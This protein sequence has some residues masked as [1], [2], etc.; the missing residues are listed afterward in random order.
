MNLFSALQASTTLTTPVTPQ[1]SFSSALLSQFELVSFA[2]S[3]LSIYLFYSL[4]HRRNLHFERQYR[5]FYDVSLALKNLNSAKGL[6]ADQNTQNDLHSIDGDLTN[7]HYYETEK[8]AVLF[9]ILL[10]VP[11]VSAFAYLYIFYF[12]MKDFEDHERMEDQILS[13]V[14]NVL[15]PMGAEFSFSRS[16]SAGE[17]SYHSF[18]VYFLLTIVTLG[19][20]ESYWLYILIREPNKHFRNQVQIEDRLIGAIAS[21]AQTPG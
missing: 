8:S 13:N 1:I 17:I 20:F 5:F 7:V 11:I 9:A 18:W 15:R 3:I 2:I 21:L 16:D 19:L 4:I 14:K 6:G 10:I 12:L